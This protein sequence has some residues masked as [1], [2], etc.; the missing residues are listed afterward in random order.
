[1]FYNN[2]ALLI[3]LF[4]Y[5]FNQVGKFIQLV[6]TFFGGFIVAFVQGWLLSLVMLCTIPPLVLAG[7]VMSTVVAKMASIGQ[8]AY[9]E[10]A[11]IV[12]QTIGTI[13]TVRTAVFFT[14]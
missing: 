12:E 11:V 8:A 7:A 9:A 13:R 6:T 10:A 1:M 4:F 14:S 3:F 5:F 2:F